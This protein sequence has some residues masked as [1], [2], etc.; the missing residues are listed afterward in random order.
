M[1]SFKLTTSFALISLLLIA[2]AGGTMLQLIRQIE[3]RDMSEMA[4]TR[5]IGMTQILGRVL[6]NDIDGLIA[7]VQGKARRNCRISCKP[8]SLAR[9]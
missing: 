4:E 8:A 2:L 6:R 5:N 1:R 3:L 7:A 9:K